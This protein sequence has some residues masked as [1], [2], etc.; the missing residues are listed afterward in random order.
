MP[1]PLV[2]FQE[3]PL[4]YY[5]MKFHQGLAVAEKEKFLDFKAICKATADT[6]FNQFA[7]IQAEVLEL[8]HEISL[9]TS[10]VPQTEE[11]DDLSSTSESMLSRGEQFVLKKAYRLAASLAHPDKGGSA[12]EFYEVTLAYKTNDVKALTAFYLAKRQESLIDLVAYYQDQSQ[13]PRI[14]LQEF[15]KDIDFQITKA[16][17]AKNHL[18]AA[19]LAKTHLNRIRLALVMQK[20]AVLGDLV[21]TVNN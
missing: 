9:I 17:Q 21:K 11:L 5:L 10:G 16:A 12:Q 3:N 1:Y 13:K 6:Y 14:Q 18:L 7:D 4:F 8:N 2:I 20:Q 15:Y 19:E